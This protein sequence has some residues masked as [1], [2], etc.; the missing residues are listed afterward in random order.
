M[1]IIE[2]YFR[3]AHPLLNSIFRVVA[4]TEIIEACCLNRLS[5]LVV[6]DE[7]GCGEETTSP[8]LRHGSL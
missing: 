5:E 6:G 7:Q 4:M 1:M 3:L 2:A 8:P